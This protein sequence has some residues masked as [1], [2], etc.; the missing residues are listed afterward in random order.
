MNKFKK[1]LAAG[2][3]LAMAVSFGACSSSA[4][5][6]DTTADTAVDASVA[7]TAT[8]KTGYSVIS[9]IS[10]VEETTL[11]IDSVCV[12]VLVGENDTVI[13]IEVDEAQTLPDLE[14]NDGTVSDDNLRTK[15]EKLEDYG[16]KST[17]E[18][19]LEWYEQIDAFEQFAI[20]KTADEISAAVSDDGYATDA[21]LSAGC[22]INVAT[23]VEATV[24][25]I[26]NSEDI[27]ASADDTLQLDINTEKYYESDETNLQ[28]DSN[29]AVVTLDADGV[30]TSCVI[31]A[32]QA[33]CTME[34][35]VFTVEEGTFQSKK[36][37]GD[38]YGMKSIS[39]IGKEWYEQAAAVEE[40]AVGKT[41]EE[42]AATAL[43]ESGYTTD[44][45]LSAGCT[46]IA[47]SIIA[48]IADAAA[49]A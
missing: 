36:E 29:Y 18:I 4:T 12:A 23:I 27:G 26:A 41:S 40:Y 34:D 14:D 39:G 48:T 37:L 44:A 42:V 33:K 2:I 20:G 11:T 13:D 46:I 1:V 21:D 7:D 35:G 31:D 3:A 43:D 8:A 19:G 47:S 24:N 9:S 16:M 49:T 17:S 25:A 15:D 22:T 32:S 5:D 38:D 10:D 28:Y 6:E 30:I 45:D